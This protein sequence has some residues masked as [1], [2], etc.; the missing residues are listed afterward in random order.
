L[1][2]ITVAAFVFLFFNSHLTFFK[3][4]N[5]IKISLLSVNKIVR[6]TSKSS[7]VDLFSM[8]VIG[9]QYAYH[10]QLKQKK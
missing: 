5:I 3:A 2:I 8:H 7:Q 1:N 6:P 10:Q 9:S 4:C